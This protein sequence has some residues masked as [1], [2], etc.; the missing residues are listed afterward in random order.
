M[1]YLLQVKKNRKKE[2]FL[3]DWPT[4]E[5]G[6]KATYILVLTPSPPYFPPGVNFINILR[7]HFCTKELFLP[8]SFCQSQNVTREKLL[9]SLSYKKCTHNTL[10]KLTPV[11]G[12]AKQPFRRV[13]CAKKSDKGTQNLV[14]NYFL[15]TF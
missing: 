11:G 2:I 13:C 10:M 1:K 4:E 3:I 14:V 8:K 5:C 12:V 15:S 7:A 6:R 9:N